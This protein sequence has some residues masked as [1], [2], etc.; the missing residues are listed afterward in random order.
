MKGELSSGDKRQVVSGNQVNEID[1]TSKS[2]TSNG[3]VN[4]F[5]KPPPA[6]SKFSQGNRSFFSDSLRNQTN[7]NDR[8]KTLLSDDIRTVKTSA[9]SK[10]ANIKIEPPS[11]N[12]FQ[13]SNETM[14]GQMS[15]GNIVL[16]KNEVQNADD[17]CEDELDH[18]L[19]RERMKLLSSKNCPSLDIHQSSKCAI[20]VPPS[21]PECRPVESKPAP[22]LKINRP[23]KRRKTVT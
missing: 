11:Y 13:N 5:S 16:V 9:I 8:G 22:S 21:A 6:L 18:M 12:E 2:G 17:A 19:L 7:E 1:R 23:R 4:P 14:L 3:T 15:F 20:N 10:L